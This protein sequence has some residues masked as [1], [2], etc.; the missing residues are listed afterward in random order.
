M[1]NNSFDTLIK[2]HKVEKRLLEINHS[3]GDLPGKIDVIKNKI[4]DLNNQSQ[5][6]NDRL[7][8]I[9][10]RKTLLTHTIQDIESK[11]SSLNDQM[12]KVK[13]NREYEALLSEIDHLNNE[14]LN[15]IKELEEF[16]EEVKKI[17]SSLMKIMK[18]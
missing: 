10:K 4:N 1:N 13:S 12:Y 8:E 15:T 5:L 2:L 11:V 14:N 16:D 17:E 3:R 7:T 6:H 9:D 18:V